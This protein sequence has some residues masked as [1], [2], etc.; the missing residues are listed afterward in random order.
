MRHWIVIF[1]VIV[2]SPYAYSYNVYKCKNRDGNTVFSQTAC[3]NTKSEYVQ[4]EPATG[5][6]DPNRQS[7]SISERAGNI[8]KPKSRNYRSSNNHSKVMKSV[9]SKKSMDSG[10]CRRYKNEA[11][12]LNAAMRSGYSSSEGEKYRGQLRNTNK[13][14]RK[15]CK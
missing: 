15:H 11:S 2:F 8:E 1:I 13:N 10:L 5:N 3:L 7:K 9:S 14:I 12:R 4:V 6:D